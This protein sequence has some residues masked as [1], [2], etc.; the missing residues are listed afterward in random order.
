MVEYVKILLEIYNLNYFCHFLLWDW[1]RKGSFF[2]RSS[3]N[4]KFNWFSTCGR[5]T[6]E[7]AKH[8][9]INLVQPRILRFENVFGS[10]ETSGYR[11]VPK[12]D[13]SRS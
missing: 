12:N 11:R 3:L 9:N 5:K 13:V 6:T 2:L 7:E 1:M 10:L 8:R 4:E